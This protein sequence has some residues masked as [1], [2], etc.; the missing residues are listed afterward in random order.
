MLKIF[1]IVVGTQKQFD[2]EYKNLS[3]NIYAH[4][5]EGTTEIRIENTQ[6]RE[7]VATLSKRVE[8]LSSETVLIDPFIGDVEPKDEKE[9][10]IYVATI[11]GVFK[12]F[13]APKWKQMIAAAHLLMED[14]ENTHDTDMKLKG[15]V[16]A[17]REHLFWG[18]RIVNE[19]VANLSEGSNK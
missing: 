10:K 11:A 4:A 13:F 1:G 12:D 18:D 19:H 9:R 16:Y 6:L 15:A 3:E 5:K 14:S 2:A 7:K 17:L 8:E